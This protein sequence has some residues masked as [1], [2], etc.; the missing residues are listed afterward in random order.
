M[1]QTWYDLLF[2]HWPVSADDLRRIVP[3]SLAIDTF[4]GQPWLAVTPFG[5]RGV[6]LRGLPPLPGVSAFPE[7]NVRSYVTLD[8]VPG[9][10]F[11]SLDAGSRLAVAVARRWY[12]LPYHHA[13]MS[14]RPAGDW[15]VYTSRRADGRAEFRAR[16]RPAGPAFEAA[17]GSL[18]AWLT[19]RYCLYTTKAGRT[20]R[21]DIDHVPWALRPAE[22]EIEVNTMAAAAGIRLPSIPPRLHFAGRQDVVA[23]A[24]RR[25]R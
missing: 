20:Y 14:M 16:Y 22:A 1:A 12:A 10:Y 11:F 4:Q 24:P 7:L 15:I 13:H 8:G 3:R 18:E 2:A 25:A 6:R 23:W 17:A 21:A 19:E 5:M 9:V